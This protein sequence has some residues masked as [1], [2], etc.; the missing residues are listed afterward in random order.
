[1]TSST[2]SWTRERN[3]RLRQPRPVT[4]SAYGLQQGAVNRVFAPE[5][6]FRNLPQRPPPEQCHRPINFGLCRTGLT[7]SSKPIPADVNLGLFRWC[8]LSANGAIHV[9]GLGVVFVPNY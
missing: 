6:G 4:L 8:R 3:D 5:C 1:M 9:R 2:S 7:A